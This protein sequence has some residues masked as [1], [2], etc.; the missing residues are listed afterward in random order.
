MLNIFKLYHELYMYCCFG[1]VGR[2]LSIGNL[3]SP[4]THNIYS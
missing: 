3:F 1:N 2:N 4:A